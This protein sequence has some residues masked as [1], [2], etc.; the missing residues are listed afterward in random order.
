MIFRSKFSANTLTNSTR[1]TLMMPCLINTK[2]L[3]S[4]LT[5]RKKLK[6]MQRRTPS[7]VS[8]LSK[9][10]ST[11]LTKYLRAIRATSS[12]T[13]TSCQIMQKKRKETPTSRCRYQTYF[14]QRTVRP[15]CSG[16]SSTKDC[17]FLNNISSKLFVWILLCKQLQ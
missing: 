11:I 2:S 6:R 7:T 17:S 10:K 3:K 15:M 8:K 5:S 16:T 1:P 9:A 12:T 13:S 14:C 4:F